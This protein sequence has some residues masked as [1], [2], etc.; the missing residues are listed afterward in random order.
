MKNP[1]ARSDVA[2]STKEASV[3]FFAEC[4]K[5][6]YEYDEKETV[7]A[8]AEYMELHKELTAF[9]RNFVPILMLKRRCKDSAELQIIWPVRMVCSSMIER[10]LFEDEFNATDRIGFAL[11]HDEA[12]IETGYDSVI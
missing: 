2:I 10:Q 1:W 6:L 4:E 8:Y 7:S 9:Y 12:D 11:Y 3:S 5:R